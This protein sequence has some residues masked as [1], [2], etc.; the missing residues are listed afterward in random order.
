MNTILL[1]ARGYVGSAISRHLQSI[2][3]PALELSREEIDYTDPIEF[4]HWLHLNYNSGHKTKGCTIINAAGY[5]GKPNVDQCEI[6]KEETIVGNVVFPA[7]VSRI[8][9]EMGLRFAHVSSGCIYDG[10]H[11]QYTED[12]PPNF[13]WES[14]KQY[15][16][17]HDADKR[18]SF[19]SGSKALAEKMIMQSNDR[20]WIFRLRIPFDHVQNK[21]NYITK[22]LS[23]GK[24]LNAEN[25]F[26]HR[27]DFARIVTHGVEHFE[28]GIYNATNPGSMTTEQVVELIIKYIG[29]KRVFSFY[30]DYDEFKQHVTTNRSNCVLDTTKLSKVMDIRP[31]EQA[32]EDAIRN[33]V[34]RSGN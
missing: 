18:C 10:Y 24:L 4:S 5:T 8:C 14:D 22:L 7:R 11:K 28:P 26:S 20:A 13:S 31:V 6:D 3:K 16:K 17:K 34:V 1:G 21:R 25:S 19:Y 32:M 12:D 30:K 2:G 27:D 15:W 29:P 33:Y 23:Y 9:Q